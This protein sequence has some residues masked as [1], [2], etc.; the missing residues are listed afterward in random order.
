MSDITDPRLSTSLNIPK[1]FLRANLISLKYSQMI[2][3]IRLWVMQACVFS[4][5]DSGIA[6]VK[7]VNFRSGSILLE[8]CTFTLACI[9]QM[10]M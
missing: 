5:D 2:I 7:K 3:F 4:K 10:E 1:S 6:L 9:A 8:S